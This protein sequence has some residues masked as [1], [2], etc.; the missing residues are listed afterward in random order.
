MVSAI[1]LGQSGGGNNS[2]HTRS[3]KPQKEFLIVIPYQFGCRQLVPSLRKL[4]NTWY[5]K[6]PHTVTDGYHDTR[7]SLRP[8]GTE[9]LHESAIKIRDHVDDDSKQVVQL[10]SDGG[11]LR[12]VNKVSTSDS[13][14]LA[15]IMHRR[16]NMQ[17][18]RKTI[19]LQIKY[20]ST[21]CDIV[22]RGRAEP[23]HWHWHWRCQK[24]CGLG[25][26][27]SSQSPVT[28]CTVGVQ[29][30]LPYR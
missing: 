29:Y 22:S 26:S 9:I 8:Y 27:T 28:F 14:A 24:V 13:S 6:E 3:P 20:Q 17:E 19:I 23:L 30:Y 5:R 10:A 7:G 4:T 16:R 18:S 15:E 11:L 1:L 21:M 2:N 25:V 12:C